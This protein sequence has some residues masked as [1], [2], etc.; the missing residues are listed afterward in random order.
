MKYGQRAIKASKLELW[1]NPNPD[2]DYEIEISFSEFTCLCP[3]SGY[4]DFATINIKYIP[5]KYVVELKS[6]K[7]HLNK[8]R[9]E[10]ISHEAAVNKIY[11][12]LKKN[13]K[14]RYIEVTGDFNSRGNVKTVIRVASDKER[15]Q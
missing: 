4:P 15:K 12:L 13:L 14:P 8:Y 11:D 1:K 5:D 3:R 9:D 7:L 6:L 2:R 10:H